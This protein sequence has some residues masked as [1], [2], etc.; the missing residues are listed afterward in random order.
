M[1]GFTQLRKE[2]RNLASRP[3]EDRTIEV[4]IIQTRRQNAHKRKY[5]AARPLAPRALRRS[6]VRSVSTGRQIRPARF[7]SAPSSA[8]RFSPATS[9]FGLVCAE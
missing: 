6:A 1:C 2:L 4:M 8:M 5:F 9:D 7:N 3:I